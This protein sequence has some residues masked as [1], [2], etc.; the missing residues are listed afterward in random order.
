M[1]VYFALYSVLA[2]LGYL[3]RN[4]LQSR[5]IAIF[6]ILFLVLFAGSRF[7][8]GCD[9]SAYE[10]RFSYMYENM[11]WFDALWAGEGGFNWLNMALLKTGFSFYALLMVCAII[12]FYGMYKFSKLATRPM[13]FIALCFPILIL[14]LGMSGIRQALAVAFLM[15]AMVAF[16]DRRRNMVIAWILLAWLFHT[17]AILFLPIAWL[18]NHKVSTIRL[19]AVILLIS[20]L[21]GLFLGERAATYNDR[22]VEQIYGESES[23]GAW[24]RYA[25]AAL[26]FL[27]LEWKRRTMAISF[28]KLFEMMRLYAFICFGLLPIGFFSSIALHRLTFYILPVSILTLLC[29]SEVA[30]DKRSERF[31]VA[32]P[33]V[34]YGTY[35]LTWFTLSKHAAS[36]YVPYQ[37]WLL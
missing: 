9:F 22:Y 21:V 19:I 26:P 30:F 15:L 36:C 29:F 20:P 16:V 18:V 31:A 4:S 12:Y 32:L 6:A 33:F 23:S 34:I 13:A 27:L 3:F 24:F 37:S 11:G 25:L 14:Q 8:V 7:E 5:Y 10:G 35:I 28:P 17:S 1:Y 2:V